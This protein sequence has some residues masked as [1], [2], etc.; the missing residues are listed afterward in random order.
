[1]TAS[2]LLIGEIAVHCTFIFGIWHVINQLKIPIN[3]LSSYCILVDNLK[4][5]KMM[6]EKD[7]WSAMQPIKNKTMLSEI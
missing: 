7:Y 2:M 4:L 1:M 3:V 6:F 5:F